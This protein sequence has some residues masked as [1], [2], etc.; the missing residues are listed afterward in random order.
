M[1]TSPASQRLRALWLQRLCWWQPL[2]LVAA[3]SIASGGNPAP[4]P[5]SFF[6][7]DKVIHLLVYGLLATSIYR[8]SSPTWPDGLRA[9]FAITL[10]VVFGLVDELHQSQTPGRMM[11]FADWLADSFGAITAVYVY[12]GWAGYRGVLEWAVIRPRKKNAHE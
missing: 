1:K 9:V 10:T 12:R 4:L 11:D 7:L 8:V 5:F 6:S 3:I 2:A